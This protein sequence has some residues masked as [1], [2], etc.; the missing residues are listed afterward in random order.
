M[1]LKYFVLSAIVILLM[2]STSFAQEN[3]KLNS[4]ASKLVITGTSTIHDWEMEAED[5]M[6]N[7]LI[8]IEGNTIK[9]IV[10]VDFVCQVEMI[11]SHNKIMDNKTYKALNSK[12]HS[13]IQFQAVSNKTVIDSDNSSSLDGSLS[14]AGSKKEITVNFL[15][16]AKNDKEIIVSGELPL[17]MSDFDV[18]APTAMMGT[19]KTG[20]EI[21]I[22]YEFVFSISNK[23]TVDIH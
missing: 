7:A 15:I 11:K 20:D 5:F 13:D 19:M 6:C 21:V 22:K 2:H 1:S 10:Q 12:E 14:I 4:S 23:Q 8:T 18:E 9:E 3:F 16:E 17:K